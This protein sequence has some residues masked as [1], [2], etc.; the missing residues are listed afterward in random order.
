[1]N[2]TIAEVCD[3]P[4]AALL[5]DAEGAPIAATPE[6]RG[7]GPGTVLYRLRA[8]RLAVAASP[9]EPASAAL[10]D[11]LL[12]AISGAS[13]ALQGA[14]R[15]RIAMLAASLRLVAGREVTTRGSSHDVVDMAL[16]GIRARTGLEVCVEGRPAFPVDAPEVVALCLVQLAV[17]AERHARTTHLTLAATDGA[18]HVLW[19]G[20]AGR[21]ELPTSRRWQDRRGWGLGFS[22]IAAD[23]VG[24]AL[25][26]PVSRPDGTVAATLELGLRDLALPLAA[27]QGQRIERATRTWDEETGCLPRSVVR[28]GSRLSACVEAAAADPGAVVSRDGWSARLAA[29]RCWVAIPP[30]GVMERARDVIDGTAHE[31]ALWDGVPEP[32]PTR[33]FALA[34]LL[35]SRL[36][37]P[38]PRVPAGVW[39]R[40]MAM[41]APA[42]R[43]AAPPCF[44]GLGALDPRICAYLAAELGG[45]L[46]LSGDDLVL[47]LGPGQDGDERLAGLRAATGVARLS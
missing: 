10:L 45:T 13:E 3:L 14:R 46:E 47:R 11:R 25:H 38:L 16:A 33:V 22:R 43:L 17:N 8:S 19:P 23:T 42:L 2:L 15:L 29:G 44:T 27:V 32:H 40:R 21:P 5:T 37:A 34:S 9:A 35:G 41:L 6:W 24:A 28:A 12:T 18:F 31:R 20:T 39:N 30:D 26:G 36:G 1:M 7:A 4:L